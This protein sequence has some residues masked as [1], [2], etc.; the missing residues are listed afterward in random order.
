MQALWQGYLAEE[1]PTWLEAYIVEETNHAV[2]ELAIATSVEAFMGGV[3]A[4]GRCCRV[5]TNGWGAGAHGIKV[6]HF[7]FLLGSGPG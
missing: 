5:D 7:M 1:C 4:A 6:R 3:G 2:R